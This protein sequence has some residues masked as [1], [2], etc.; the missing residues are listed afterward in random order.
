MS[1]RKSIT[2]FTGSNLK[3]YDFPELA[4][5][6]GGIQPTVPI[7]VLA[8]SLFFMTLAESKS[9]SVRCVKLPATSRLIKRFC[10]F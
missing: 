5:T 6:S 8:A 7:I 2:Q 3:V 1:Y 4:K 9:A 10:D